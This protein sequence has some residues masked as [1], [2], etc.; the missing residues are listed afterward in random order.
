[1]PNNE[2]L[3]I[4]LSIWNTKKNALRDFEC[5]S[6]EPKPSRNSRTFKFTNTC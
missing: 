1:M 3:E 6:Y 5:N 2:I 4:T